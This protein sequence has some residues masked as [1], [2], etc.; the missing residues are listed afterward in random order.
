[1]PVK[2]ETARNR[3]AHLSLREKG[4]EA[5]KELDRLAGYVSE[6]TE[7]HVYRMAA[8]IIRALANELPIDYNNSLQRRTGLKLIDGGRGD[9]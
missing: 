6:S 1:M 4:Y 2:T 9:A 8:N 5:A 7:S 3:Y